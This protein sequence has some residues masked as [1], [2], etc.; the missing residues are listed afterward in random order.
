M[1]MILVSLISDPA[2]NSR[3]TL[4]DKETKELAA[5]MKARIDQGKDALI[6]PILVEKDGER[7]ELVA[8]SR[9][10]AA[11]KVL[12]LTEIQA[13]VE[14]FAR[15]EDKVL[16]NIVENLLRKDLTTFEEARACHT[17]RAAGLKLREVKER[18]GLSESHISKLVTAYEGL[19]P[20]IK[21][22]WQNRS[23]IAT[24]DFL[25]E[26]VQL[27]PE[28]Q[29][30]TFN[31]KEAAYA[32]YANDGEDEEG[33]DKPKKKPAKVKRNFTV[34]REIYDLVLTALKR[35]KADMVTKQMLIDSVSYL[36][37]EKTKIDGLEIFPEKIVET[38][39]KKSTQ[40]KG[41]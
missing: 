19:V 23:P 21:T 16:D 6:N 36:V 37:G 15:P 28:E 4:F 22:A 41:K 20:A 26:V 3:L 14:T 2:W 32:T 31:A 10:L 38:K 5:S 8:G 17:L 40:K 25:S 1:T 13:S 12:G 33:S 34:K 7:Y 39:P 29:I 35:V 18:T 30:K 9:R 24:T 11:A 27:E